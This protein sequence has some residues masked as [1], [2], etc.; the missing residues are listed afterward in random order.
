M[1][2]YIYR[3]T[4]IVTNK[5]YIGITN[6]F[7]R[8][9]KRHLSELKSGIHHSKKLQ[10]AWN[11]YGSENFEWNYRELNIQEYEELYE[12]E[13][14]EISKYNS[15]ND[16]YNCT[17]GGDIS[18]W[19]RKVN[20]EDVFIF[21]CIQEEYGDGYG[22]TCEEIFQWAKGTASAAKR[23]IKYPKAISKF[24][25]T[26]KELR[27]KVAQE[28]YDKLKLQEKVLERQLKQG[29]S[30]KAY[31]LQE[32]DFF[33]AFLAQEKGYSYT[34]VAIYLGIS[35]ATVK[36]WYNGRSRKKERIKFQQISL[37]DKEKILKKIENSH[38]EAMGHDKFIKTKEED[39]IDFLCYDE[40]FSQNDS[41]IQRIFGWS[42]GIC[43]QIRNKKHYSITKAKVKLYTEEE[44]Y[45]I[46]C[47]LNG[48]VKIAE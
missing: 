6:D 16:G 41:K 26:P 47:Q 44:R 9:K 7:E 11:Q 28:N 22:K 10:Q 40:F 37:S 25:N 29:G 32:E 36:D 42:E 35:P 38:L 27:Q 31:M 4:N 39:V 45:E 23:Q 46:A 18:S 20:E 3:I 48:R 34:Q 43:H 30:S 24:E 1:V 8:R 17:I 15:Y 19:K 12:I 14:K 33:F 13:K 2:G 21:L 5:V